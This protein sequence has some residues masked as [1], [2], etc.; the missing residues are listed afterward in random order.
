MEDRRGG[1][2][3]RGGIKKIGGVEELASDGFKQRICHR[4]VLT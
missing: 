2:D 1:K 3:R 4:R